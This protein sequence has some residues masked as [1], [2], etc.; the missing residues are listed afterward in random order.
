MMT[1][2]KDKAK[3]VTLKRSV[4]IKAVVTDR[5]KEYVRFEINAGLQ[6]AKAQVDH[7]DSQLKDQSLA[8]VVRE[9]YILEREQ[10]HQNISD[11]S[12]RLDQIETLQMG[13]YFMQGTVD[14]FVAV[15]VGDNLYEKLGGMEILI[16]DGIVQDIVPVSD[17]SGAGS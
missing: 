2:S 8:P 16:E 5:F 9:K 17:A 15:N 4:T 13:S 3:S 14:G 12:A 10:L 1:S 6:M 11:F 7:I